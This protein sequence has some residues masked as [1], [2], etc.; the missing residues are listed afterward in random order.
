[1]T[2]RDRERENKKRH[3]FSPVISMR[4]WFF[5]KINPIKNYS[6]ITRYSMNMQKLTQI[7]LQTIRTTTINRN[8]LSCF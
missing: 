3:N 2:E 4:Y 8:K 7:G 5:G 1:M 6:R